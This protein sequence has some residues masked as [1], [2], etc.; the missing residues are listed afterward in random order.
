M[1]AT[2]E[3]LFQVKSESGIRDWLDGTPR[4]RDPQ[5][6]EVMLLRI[7]ARREENLCDSLFDVRL[8]WLFALE[9]L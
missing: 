9:T 6:P 8:L 4:N 2:R 1:Y 7:Y 5:L 3:K